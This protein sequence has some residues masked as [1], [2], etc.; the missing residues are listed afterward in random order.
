MKD[1]T[2]SCFLS[3]W[4][5]FNKMNEGKEKIQ[6]LFFDIMRISPETAGKWVRGETSPK[7]EQI[8]RLRIF[9]MS[10]GYEITELEGVPSEVIEISKLIAYGFEEVPKICIYLKWKETWELFR[11][12]N[13]MRKISREKVSLMRN[14]LSDGKVKENIFVID[15]SIHDSKSI[16]YAFLQTNLPVSTK[17]SLGSD[18]SYESL[19]YLLRAMGSLADAGL[20]ILL[21]L[22]SE[23]GSDARDHMRTTIDTIEIAGKLEKFSKFVSGLCS[24]K[25]RS[26]NYPKRKGGE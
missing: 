8:L 3:F 12:L 13:N 1:S 18:C 4:D 16:F 7:G 23:D 5:S 2:A 22:L 14:Y 21:R 20:P 11:Y 26:V 24:E 9:L 19:G 15:E 10:L 6:K 17:T 25:A